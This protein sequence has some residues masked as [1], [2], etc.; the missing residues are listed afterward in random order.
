MGDAVGCAITGQQ[1]PNGYY[2]LDRMIETCVRHGTD[3]ACCGTCMDARGLG[4]E[5]LTKGA[6]RSTL[7]ELAEWTLWADQV[8]T[9]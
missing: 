3:V 5:L 8:I 1:V 6:H 9:F 7:A 4:E 2:H